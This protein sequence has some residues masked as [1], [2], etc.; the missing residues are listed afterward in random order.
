MNIVHQSG[1][2]AASTTSYN[3][4]TDTAFMVA[5]R[6]GS[7]TG[8]F[9]EFGGGNGDT[10]T[11]FN[12][13]QLMNSWDVG[14]FKV[15]LGWADTSFGGDAVMNVSNVYGQHSS[16]VGDIGGTVSAINNSGFINEMTAIGAWVGNDLGYL[17]VALV[18]PGGSA[19]WTVNGAA[20]SAGMP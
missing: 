12:N 7:N 9:V 17:Q 4:P 16:A 10:G 19:G 3:V 13:V 1:G 11:A 8:A 2:G 5:G 18:A 14:G 15:G 20:D 6:V